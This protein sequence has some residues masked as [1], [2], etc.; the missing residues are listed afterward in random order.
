MK[1]RDKIVQWFQNL[2]G[3][4]TNHRRDTFH[5]T[6]ESGK[7]LKRSGKYQDA[8]TLFDHADEIARSLNDDNLRILVGLHR[9]E[10][11]IRM[12]DWARAEEALLRLKVQNADTPGAK[13][14]YVIISQGIMSQDRGDWATARE[15]YEEALKQARAARA[16]G[17]EGRAQAHLADTYMHEDNASFAVYLLEEA[18]PKLNATDDIEMSSYFVGRLGEALIAVGRR[19][20][21]QQLIGRALRLAEHMQYKEYEMRWRQVLAVQ[22]M[23]DGSYSDARRHL[24]L[25]LSLLERGEDQ[26]QQITTFSR[27]S[28]ACLR[29]DEGP[30]AL[31]YA[32]QAVDLARQDGS[33]PEQWLALGS[34]GV[35]LRVMGDYQN[36]VETLSQVVPH[37]ETLILTSADHSYVEVLRNLAASQAEVADFTTAEN[38]YQLALDHAKKHH[39]PLDEA[40]TYRD[41]GIMFTRQSRYHDVIKMWLNALEIYEQKGHSARVARLYCDIATMRKRIGQEKRAIK[42]YEQALM[43]LSS[44]DDVE[45]RGIVLSNAATAYV[46]QG[47]V[48]TAEAFF[49]EAI[50]IAL[51]LHDHHAEATRRGNYGWFLMITG[52]AQRSIATLTYALRQSENLGLKLQ[53]AVQTDNLALAYDEL[54]QVGMA[55]SYHQEALSKIQE[56]KQPYWESMIRVHLAHSHITADNLAEAQKLLEH[57]QKQ[58]ITKD[59]GDIAVRVQLGMAR[60]ALKQQEFEQALAYANAAVQRAEQSGMRRWLADSL[61]LRSEIYSYQANPQAAMEDWHRAEQ[62]YEFLLIPPETKAPSWIAE[63]Q[64]V[65]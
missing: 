27:L 61:V 9:V 57:L 14:A 7:R 53:A 1:R 46:D 2:F 20:E 41:L 13:S 31:D 51:N 60:I 49:V 37:Y 36:A 22:A 12:S 3:A 11:Y 43:L 63:T 55:L 45:T 10:V 32:R 50:K 54:G 59:D 35:V 56:I 58:D 19:S 5:Y 52:R 64:D 8:L 65:K 23:E 16:S 38:T 4:G 24:M 48:E 29:L 26:S 21:G 33:K 25:V 40:G 30:A 39:E 15:L 62:F 47:D 6:V 42:D 28:K 44:I 18:I 34:H 17:P